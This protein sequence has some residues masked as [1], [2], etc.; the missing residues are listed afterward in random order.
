[1]PNHRRQ[2][3]HKAPARQSDHSGALS[4]AKPHTKWASPSDH[5]VCL[6]FAPVSGT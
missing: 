6:H 3:Q 4:S 2:A 5:A 1:M